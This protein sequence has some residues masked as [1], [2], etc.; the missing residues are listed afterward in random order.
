MSG[1]EV[2]GVVLGALPLIIT[3]VDKYQVTAKIIKNFRH[4]EPYIQRLVQALNAQWF[5]VESELDIIWKETFSREDFI[6]P[7]PSP[8]D[9][10]SPMVAQ[11]I[12]ETL[13]VGYEHYI[14]ALSECEQ[15]LVE[16]ATHLRGLSSDT[17]Q[18][19]A[20]LVQA[21]PPK[22]NGSYEFTK[23][24]KFALK[25]DDLM[26]HIKDLNDATNGL[27]RIREYSRLRCPVTLQSTS[28]ATTRI[29]SS[30]D[31]I[32][33]HACRLYSTIST[34]YGKSCHPE[35]EAHLFLQS[36]ADILLTKYR[37][38]KKTPVTFT[39]SF[40][41]AS[42][43]DV[44]IPSLATE[45]KVS[46]E[47]ALI[48]QSSNLTLSSRGSLHSSQYSSTS[49]RRVSYQLDAQFETHCKSNTF[50]YPLG[51]SRL[52][53][54]PQIIQDLCLHLSKSA[55]LQGLHLSQDDHL[56]YYNHEPKI[57]PQPSGPASHVHSL[58][59]IL[60]PTS[61][62]KLSPV[63]RIALSFSIASSVM[64]L[65]DTKWYRFPITSSMICLVCENSGRPDSEPRPFISRKFTS[66]LEDSH[67]L[68]VKRVM[69]ELGIVLLELWQVR[70]LASYADECQKPYGT[71]GA[72]YDLARHWLDVCIG[73]ILPA[74][75]EVI[76]RCIE[77]TF[78]TR[79]ADLKWIDTEFRKSVYD[80]V[81]KPLGKLVHP[82]IEE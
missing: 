22:S 3:A 59:E 71:L 15:A 44:C 18:D 57:R 79:T 5:C 23:K 56:C 41:P 67:A 46:E 45:V 10:K 34:V 40:G 20:V 62:I 39:V 2:A 70:T 74:F 81:V 19:L 50:N 13:G 75:S 28:S 49:T 38:P 12:Q 25:K 8:D 16:I 65:N 36:R 69:L 76:T 29:V 47:D 63:S 32:R 43:T 64:Q 68:N 37:T 11:A 66:S 1:L 6:P 42:H 51:S 35:H 78:V 61:S 7:P 72:R 14:A 26:R 33:R 9:F 77:C 4:K 53:P 52:A 17:T 73:N 82:H 60:Q 27:S 30:F 55:E 48:P 58:E 31:S 54:M 21:N 80:Y 24:I